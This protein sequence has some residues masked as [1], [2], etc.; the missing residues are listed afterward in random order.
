M[1]TWLSRTGSGKKATQGMRSF[2]KKTGKESLNSSTRTS[3][4]PRRSS[5]WTPMPWT[6]NTE[7]KTVP[8]GREDFF[9]S[10]MF[11]FSS[12]SSCR[13][14]VHV[15]KAEE[16]TH[17]IHCS[18]T[19][20]ISSSKVVSRLRMLRT[21]WIPSSSSTAR[22]TLATAAPSASSEWS[23][24]RGRSRSRP[25]PALQPPPARG[26]GR[27]SRETSRPR[28]PQPPRRPPP[29]PRRPTPTRR[30]RRTFRDSLREPLN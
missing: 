14:H 25:P 27:R 29:A 23:T 1:K 4:L 8:A 22:S 2:R 26:G 12:N 11:C 20:T 10:T 9:S 24:R 6:R 3:S 17:C 19:V 13:C 7:G 30:P 15:D 28:P 21:V 5:R 18:L 16:G